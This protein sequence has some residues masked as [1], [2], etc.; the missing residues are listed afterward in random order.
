MGSD[1]SSFL[2]YEKAKGSRIYSLTAQNSQSGRL[3]RKLIV[4]NEKHSDSILAKAICRLHGI[5]MTKNDDDLMKLVEGSSGDAEILKEGRNKE[6]NRAYSCLADIKL[7]SSDERKREDG[8]RL[9]KSS[10]DAGDGY[11]LLRLGIAYEGRDVGVEKNEKTARE[12]YGKCKKS[13]FSRC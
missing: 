4:T 10:A 9:L 7:S 13:W 12:L 2:A 3:G 11:G 5:G 6:C 8:L 1:F